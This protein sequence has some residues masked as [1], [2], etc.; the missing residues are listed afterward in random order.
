MRP[1]EEEWFVDADDPE[2]VSYRTHND[3]GTVARFGGCPGEKDFARARLAAK[4][5]A[6]ARALQAMLEARSL[7]SV[8]KAEAEKMAI[9]AL[10][11]AE[12]SL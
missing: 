11:D 6:M 4:A 10:R 1:W 12:V 7:G 9:E 3:L 5:P 2:Y 8:S